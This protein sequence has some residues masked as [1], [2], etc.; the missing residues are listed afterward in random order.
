MPAACAC[1]VY[2]W[3]LL[4]EAVEQHPPHA[5]TGGGAHAYGV[6]EALQYTLQIEAVVSIIPQGERKGGG[7]QAG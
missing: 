2:R 6:F 7:R 3:D 4:I 5:R 1:A